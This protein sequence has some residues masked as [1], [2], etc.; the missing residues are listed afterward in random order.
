[1]DRLC[2]FSIFESKNPKKKLFKFFFFENFFKKFFDVNFD[3]Q[4]EKWVLKILNSFLVQ[5]LSTF[6][7][8]SEF[9]E[10][11]GARALPRAPQTDRNYQR[12]N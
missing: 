6:S 2:I 4:F 7:K 9:I 12:L 1:M 8:E 5:S 10:I 11:S 3:F